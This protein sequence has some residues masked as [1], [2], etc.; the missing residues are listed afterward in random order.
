MP[1]QSSI[2]GQVLR[3]A[4]TVRIDSLEQVREDPEIF[5][6]PDGQLLYER[7]MEEGLRTGCDLPLIGRR[8]VVGVLMRPQRSENGFE[9]DDVV[10]LEQ[11]AR[12]VAIAVENALDYEKATK[13]RDKETKQRLYLEEEIRAEFGE[14]VG[15]SPN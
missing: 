1:M 15:G 12:Q 5:G 8:G 3:K 10:F 14:I 11:V 9:K 6:N 2:S 13:D 4:K 7:V